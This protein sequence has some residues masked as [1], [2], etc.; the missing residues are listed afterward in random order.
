MKGIIY[1]ALLAIC[2][3]AVAQE[4]VF[5][6]SNLKEYCDDIDL[7]ELDLYGAMCFGYVTGVAEAKVFDYMFC[8]PTG[9]NRD[10]FVLVVS[11]YLSDHPEKLHRD[12]HILV[13]GALQEA[14]PCPKL[15]E[16]L[17]MQK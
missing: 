3:N 2:E 7:S 11:K 9:S 10:Q 6:G 16:N 12:A 17:P 4:A 8:P 13:A 5:S 1:A 14:F 15:F